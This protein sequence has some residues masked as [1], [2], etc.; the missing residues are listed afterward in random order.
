MF[1][2]K[3]VQEVNILNKIDIK[4]LKQCDLHRK[5]IKDKRG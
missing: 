3:V 2:F 1:R 5:G 4:L